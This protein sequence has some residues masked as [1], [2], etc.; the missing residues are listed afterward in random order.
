M[1][2]HITANRKMQNV[3]SEQVAKRVETLCLLVKGLLTRIVDQESL[4]AMPRELR[5][6]LVIL[7]TS[8]RQHMPDMLL[9]ILNGFLILRVYS[10]AV[11]SP[12]SVGIVPMEMAPTGTSRRN[13][14]LVAKVLQSIGNFGTT[15]GR[16]E[17]FMEQ[18]RPFIEQQVP[19]LSEFLEKLAQPYSGMDPA[20]LT[21]AESPDDL[22][23]KPIDA[24][25]TSLSDLFE[26][27]RT[28]HCSAP[29]LVPLLTEETNA[30]KAQA[31]QHDRRAGGRYARATISLG[32]NK[33][34]P[35]QRHRPSYS[36][37]F[38]ATPP[39]TL[40]PEALPP[41]EATATTTTQTTVQTTA[42]TR[43][44]PPQRKPP[45][46]PVTAGA[47][48]SE[49]LV[50]SPTATTAEPQLRRAGSDSFGASPVQ[51]K[52]RA[53][54][55]PVP[56][57][58]PKAQP[59]PQPAF[60]PARP[61]FSAIGANATTRNAFVCGAARKESWQASLLT[62]MTQ[63]GPPPV[64]SHKN[65][66]ADHNLTSTAAAAAAA[67]ATTTPVSS[68]TNALVASPGTPKSSNPTAA[69][70]AALAQAM[71]SAKF[72]Y[73]GPSSPKCGSVFYFVLTRFDFGLL[74]NM[75]ALIAF[76][77]KTMDSGV[78]S[79]AY[80][81]VVDMSW[82]TVS[83]PAAQAACEALRDFWEMFPRAYKKNLRQV[84]VLQPTKFYH[85]ASGI[86]RQF[87]SK[88]AQRKV[89]EVYD[90]KQLA[91]LLGVNEE[92]VTIPESSKHSAS[93]VYRVV[94]VNAHG[95]KQERLIKFT[96]DSLLNLDTHATKI[97]NEKLLSDI[98]EISLA[99]PTSTEIFMRFRSS[100]TGSGGSSSSG[101]GG[102]GSFAS[103]LTSSGSGAGNK[104]V[105]TVLDAVR[106]IAGAPHDD[107]RT[108]ICSTLAERDAILQDLF[109]SGFRCGYSPGRQEFKVV[110]VNRAGKRQ[111]RVFKLTVDSLMNVSGAEIRHEMCFAGIEGVKADTDD[112]NVVWL[113]Y[114]S[115]TH[116]RKIITADADA[117]IRS[118]QECLHRYRADQGN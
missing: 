103:S 86:V 107:V 17:P 59:Q 73:M 110:K 114:K 55:L 28:L 34:V 93:R 92:H 69:G 48:A 50:T 75:P 31:Q 8:A 42:T 85:M 95:K 26:L 88:K 57:G 24:R 5:C 72:L 44:P 22:P 11:A 100:S 35:G 76:V 1:T 78:H 82:S 52:S 27:H 21:I 63:L 102:S 9:Q 68:P 64:F 105:T 15:V 104:V 19:V 91:R 80:T 67:A 87:V 10:P 39:A 89:A 66:L 33:T 2:H 23:Y 7:A 4:A 40:P 16:K 30:A 60:Q 118:L 3:S 58:S 96:A 77:T 6:L 41:A 116:W 97:H 61:Q 14:V 101:I 65:T 71:E 81:L 25:E 98:D 49:T 20:Y 74:D 90:W 108:Y 115:E 94:K 38:P 79:G 32:D 47:A 106:M 99:S 36:M 62:V 18:L 113:K 84:V 54:G 12:A 117:F 37:S 29:K 111:E 56:G 83:A 109:A 70:S 13:L 51:Q 112:K 45:P 53:A 46:P 43:P